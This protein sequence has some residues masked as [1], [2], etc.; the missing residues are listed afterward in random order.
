MEAINGNLPFE[1]GHD[2]FSDKVDGYGGA[3][4]TDG[5]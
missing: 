4:S 5:C 1:W 3:V 2:T